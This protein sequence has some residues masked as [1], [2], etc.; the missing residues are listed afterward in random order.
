MLSGAS[1]AS[2]GIDW[3]IFLLALEIRRQGSRLPSEYRKK[4]HSSCD[5]V[6]VQV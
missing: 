1:F 4:L 3:P 5:E 6:L 2:A